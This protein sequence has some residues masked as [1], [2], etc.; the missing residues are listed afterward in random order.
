MSK[1]EPTVQKYMSVR[2]KSIESTDSIKKAK[3]VMSLGKI[4]HLPVT[5][6]GKVIGVVT[7]RDIKLVAGFEEIDAEEVVVADV[8]SSR[9]FIVRPDTPLHEVAAEMAEKHYGSAVVE[10]N[11]K[12]VGIFTTVDACRAL[13]EILTTRFHAH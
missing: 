2:P 4:R 10:Q 7:D 3:D 1:A 9:P 11:G 13:A 5:R 12:L 6:G 8:C